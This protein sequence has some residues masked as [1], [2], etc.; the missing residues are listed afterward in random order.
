MHPTEL[1]WLIDARRPRKMYG[2]STESEMASLHADL[3]AM[4]AL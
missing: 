2:S 1:W 4:G 3:K